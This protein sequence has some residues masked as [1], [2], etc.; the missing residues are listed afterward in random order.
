MYSIP[1]KFLA[2]AFICVIDGVLC[3]EEWKRQSQT[4][5]SGSEPTMSECVDTS[6]IDRVSMQAHGILDR[7]NCYTRTL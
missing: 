1:V 3:Q 2:L 6:C 7:V 5:G 4:D